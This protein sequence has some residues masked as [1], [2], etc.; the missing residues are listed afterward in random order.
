VCNTDGAPKSPAEGGVTD[1]APLASRDH[2]WVGE[3][4]FGMLI[5]HRMPSI[6]DLTC[7]KLHDAGDD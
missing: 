6:L 2:A 4:R 5:E 7:D 3:A 1:H